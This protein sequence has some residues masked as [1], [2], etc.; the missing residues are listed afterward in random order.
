MCPTPK[1]R[2][3][4]SRRLHQNKNEQEPDKAG[5]QTP[6]NPTESKDFHDCKGCP[7]GHFPDTSEHHQTQNDKF[8]PEK[9]ALCVHQLF[10]QL[11]AE[12]KVVIESWEDLPEEIKP[13][14]PL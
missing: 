2:G 13:K 14:F 8:L 12:L 11:P 9:C 1:I 7:E 10:D 3:F 6:Q 4:D 5:S